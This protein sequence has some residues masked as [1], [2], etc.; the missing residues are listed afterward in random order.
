MALGVNRQVRLG[1]RPE[2]IRDGIE[3]CPDAIGSLYR[4]ENVGKLLIQL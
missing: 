4:G 1:M 3:A 2:G